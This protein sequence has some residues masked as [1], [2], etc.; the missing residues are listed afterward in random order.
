MAEMQNVPHAVIDAIRNDCRIPDKKLEALNIFA[1]EVADKRGWVSEAELDA[2]LDAGYTKTQ[3]LEVILAV[4]Y[5]TL[6]NYV[7]HIANTPVDEVFE[8]KEWAAPTQTA[9]A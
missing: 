4:T 8:G 9:V 2:F 3:I 7:N 5:K 1:S 6:S